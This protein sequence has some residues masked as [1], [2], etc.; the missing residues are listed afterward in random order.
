[1]SAKKLSILVVNLEILKNNL[2]LN[3]TNACWWQLTRRIHLAFIVTFSPW[4]KWQMSIKMARE[5]QDV[6]S[7]RD[8]MLASVKLPSAPQTLS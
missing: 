3:S 7:S 8:L 4:T 6:G 1:M 2:V 5:L